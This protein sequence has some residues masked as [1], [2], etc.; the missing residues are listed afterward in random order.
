M[1]APPRIPV[2]FVNAKH[3]IELEQLL[4]AEEEKAKVV[5]DESTMEAIRL[6]QRDVNATGIPN[7]RRCVV[8]CLQRGQ[9][10]RATWLPCS[11]SHEGA[12]WAHDSRVGFAAPGSPC[13]AGVLDCQR[14]PHR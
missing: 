14:F 11:D 1:A 5:A 2:F 7:L 8:G 10:S 9:A 6:L 4:A 3:A 12:G 13:L